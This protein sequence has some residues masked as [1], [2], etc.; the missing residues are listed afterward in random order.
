MRRKGADLPRSR[1][2]RAV[3]SSGLSRPR[4]AKEPAGSAAIASH[5]SELGLGCFQWS[6]GSGLPDDNALATVETNGQVGVVV[7]RTA[8]VRD[9]ARCF[10]EGLP[11]T[12]LTAFELA[13]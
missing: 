11:F 10:S 13:S 8:E 7:S 4:R 5:D 12:R 6:G 1:K 9:R 3:I 2:E